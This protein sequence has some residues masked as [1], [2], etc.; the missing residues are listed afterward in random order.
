MRQ[1]PSSLSSPPRS[2]HDKY[3]LGRILTL[4]ESHAHFGHSGS[5]HGMEMKAG[6]IITR[7]RATLHI[8]TRLF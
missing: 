5:D 6:D 4:G 3:D 7:D 8:G 1:E 2:Y